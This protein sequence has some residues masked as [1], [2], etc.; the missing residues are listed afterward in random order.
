ML[1]TFG[2]TAVVAPEG[3][4]ETTGM[5]LAKSESE[6]DDWRNV[7]WRLRVGEAL[8]GKGRNASVGWMERRI[9]ESENFMVYTVQINEFTFRSGRVMNVMWCC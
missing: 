3:E 7:W 8:L 4:E 1:Y 6:G 5:G 9:M 2:F